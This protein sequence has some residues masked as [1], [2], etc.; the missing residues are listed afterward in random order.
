[1][2]SWHSADSTKANVAAAV[3]QA[4]AMP[5]STTLARH[6]RPHAAAG[7]PH[8]AADVHQQRELQLNDAGKG[9]R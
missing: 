7:S 9:T 8:M 6:S 4:N 5:Q 1:M 3:V 2:Q